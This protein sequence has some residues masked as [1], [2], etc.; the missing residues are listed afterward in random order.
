MHYKLYKNVLSP[1]NGMNLYRGCTHGCIYCD[2]RS[3][4]YQMDHHFEDIEVKEHAPQL[5]ED[6][7][8]RKR[9][10][11]MISTGAMG[12][13]Y[14]P[15][16]EKLKYTRKSLEIIHKYGYGLAIHTKSALI[17]RDLDLLE[18]IHKKAKCVVQ[19][20]M[21]TF[22]EDLSKVIEPNVATTRER[23]NVLIELKQRNI[24]T[25]IWLTPILPFI[26]DTEENIQGIL[27][28]GA[29]SGVKGIMTFGIGLTLRAGNREYFYHQLDRHF[30]GLKEKY[31][32]IYG[33]SYEIH[34]PH[35]LELMSLITEFCVKH[36]IL[37]NQHEI[38]SYLSRFEIP[39]KDCQLRMF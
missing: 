5:L 23:F 19:L 21:T 1:K 8:K 10:K 3:L 2:S 31:K 6:A 30:P 36:S 13:P 16:E 4:C 26:N 37:S 25:V 28:Y 17:L 29:E 7:L 22:D 14:V 18:A 39:E 24:P 35:K 12:D 27:A 11:G 34:S 9:N 38:F 15:I 20:T 33:N 32:R